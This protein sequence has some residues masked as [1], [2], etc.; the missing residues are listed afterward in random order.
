MY[1]IEIENNVT[2]Q[3]YTYDNVEDKNNGKKLFYKFYIDTSNLDDGEYTLSLYDDNKLITS[4]LLKIGDFN[5]KSI[6]YSKGANVYVD[7]KPDK[8]DVAASGIKFGYS[9]FTEIPDYYDFS[10]VISMYDMFNGCKNLTTISPIDISNVT[11]MSYMFA[12]CSKL[13]TIPQFDTSKVESMGAM[14]SACYSLQSIPFLDCGNITNM[15]RF[16]GYYNINSLTELGGFKNLKTSV[17]TGGFLD[18]A[19]NLTVDSLMNV[20]N[21]LWDWSGN[22]DG[23]APLNDGTMY[24][25]GTTHTLKF[26]QTNLDKLTEEQIAVATNKGWTLIA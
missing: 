23:K 6:Q 19:P 1:K 2:H 14:F 24:N 11:D 25:F 5:N 21:Y 3:K 15:Y 7:A 8:I 13:I 16:L 17:Y 22:T 4:E 10:N 20:I 9:K 12:N 26:G 18:Y